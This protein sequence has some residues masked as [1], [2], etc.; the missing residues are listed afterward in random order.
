MQRKK[1]E[2]ICIR[3]AA[4]TSSCSRERSVILPGR[5]RGG[6]PGTLEPPLLLLLLCG[7]GS[8]GRGTR[9]CGTQRDELLQQEVHSGSISKHLSQAH[10]PC[11]RLRYPLIDHILNV[12]AFLPFR[13]CG[14]SSTEHVDVSP[15]L[16]RASAAPWMLLEVEHTA[17]MVLE[18]NQRLELGFNGGKGKFASARFSQRVDWMDYVTKAGR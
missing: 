18:Y 5:A 11:T 8:V 14:G 4:R 7:Q 1:L 10:Y 12:E 13:M 17:C 2:A 6:L 16:R 15:V 3:Y 9:R